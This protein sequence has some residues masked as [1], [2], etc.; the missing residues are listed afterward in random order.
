MLLSHFNATLDKGTYYVSSER[1][2]KKF[3]R[4][5]FIAKRGNNTG[6]QIADL[7]AYPLGKK[8]S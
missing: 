1:L 5:D 7:C 2:K 3:V 4:F 6:L 8:S